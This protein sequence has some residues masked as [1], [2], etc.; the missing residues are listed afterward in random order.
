MTGG[1]FNGRCRFWLKEKS[2]NKE[3]APVAF[4]VSFFHGFFF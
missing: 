2:K 4:F 1:N 3:E